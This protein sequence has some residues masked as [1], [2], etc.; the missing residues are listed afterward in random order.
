[1]LFMKIVIVKLVTIKSK[2]SII[3]SSHKM[4][5]MI[6]ITTRKCSHGIYKY[7]SFNYENE[8]R[9]M[10]CYIHKENMVNVVEKIC[11]TPMYIT[12]VTDNIKAIVCIVL[13]ICFLM[14]P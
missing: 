14:N 10:F 12:Q 3:L 6:N 2:Y 11:K 9:G 8:K 7:P 1:M 4:D 13:V 5:N